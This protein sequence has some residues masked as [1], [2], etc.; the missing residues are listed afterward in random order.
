MKFHLIG[1]GGAGMSVVAELLFAEGHQITGSDRSSSEYTA[2]LSAL[3]IK[4]YLGHA[5]ENVPADSVIVYSSAIK[6][7]NPELLIAQER[8]QKII[9]RSQA[10]TLASGTK[11]FIAVAGAHGKTS[12]SAMIAVAFDYLGLDPSRAIGGG[13]ADGSSGGHFGNGKMIVAEADE[14]DGSFLNYRPRIALVTNVEPDHLDHYGSKENFMQAFLDFAHCIIP[15]GLLI[16]CADHPGSLLLAEN[17]ANAGIRVHTYGTGEK[18]DFSECHAKLTH[19]AA[20]RSSENCGDVEIIGEQQNQKIKLSL[21]VPGKHMLLNSVGALLAGIE[22]GADGENMAKG[23]A[24]FRGTARRFEV[25]AAVDGITVIDDY[26]HHPT[27][28]FAA[29]TTAKELCAGK[30]HVLFQ[31]H[32]YSRTTNFKREFAQA[33]SLAD[34]VI[35]TSAYA[36]RETPDDG[37]DGDVIAELLPGSLFIADM[38]ESAQKIVQGTHCGD[39]IITMGAGDVTKLGTIIAQELERGAY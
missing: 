10:L 6:P 31:P 9:H 16:C 33:L 19:S 1:I 32:L 12:A 30:V 26:A 38:E 8:G 14:S 24:E 18:P 5:A 27:E 35:I 36:A 4:T 37:D 21:Q 39:F 17:A 23:L 15:G 13:L 34:R 11:D 2:H 3:G 29:L 20:N 25:R 22:S 7:D 28:V